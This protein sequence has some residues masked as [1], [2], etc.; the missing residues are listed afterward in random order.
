VGKG[1]ENED[2]GHEAESTGLV[3]ALG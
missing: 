3:S 2:A 1:G